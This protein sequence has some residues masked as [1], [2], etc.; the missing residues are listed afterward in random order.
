MLAPLII[1]VILVATI[2]GAF[3]LFVLKP[4]LG[5]W[6]RKF[7]LPELPAA[8]FQLT[9][10]GVLAEI[11]FFS[12]WSAILCPPLG[13]LLSAR[14]LWDFRMFLSVPIG[15]GILTAAIAFAIWRRWGGK[16]RLLASGLAALVFCAVAFVAAAQTADRLQTNSITQLA[17]ECVSRIS[18]WESVQIAGEEFQFSAHVIAKK[19]GKPFGWSF[20]ELKFYPIP[21][22]VVGNIYDTCR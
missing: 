8:I 17:P 18:F 13:L 9:L 21:A 12:A 14:R 20:K 16:T 19:D 6:R 11:V 10:V 1:V 7:A 5:N 3:L 2:D 22:S 4:L 15:I